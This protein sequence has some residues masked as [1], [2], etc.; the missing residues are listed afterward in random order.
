MK[1]SEMFP[2][3]YLKVGDFPTPM[4]LTLDRVDWENM[5]DADGN[6]IEKPVLYFQ[7]FPKGLVLNKTN[8]D[9]LSGLFGN[10]SDNWKGARVTIISVKVSAFGKTVD[11]LRFDEKAPAPATAPITPEQINNVLGEAEAPF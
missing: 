6:E 5:H 3:R 8:G 10:E 7:E 2:A 9:V 11:A 4:V 1:T